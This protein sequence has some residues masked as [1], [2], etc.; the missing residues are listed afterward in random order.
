MDKEALQQVLAQREAELDEV[1]KR[2]EAV[3]V[4]MQ[5]QRLLKEEI[6]LLRGALNGGAQLALS[7][8]P[9]ETSPDKE[10]LIDALRRV[11]K[12]SPTRMSA[13]EITA[14]LRKEGRRFNKKDKNGTNTVRGLLLGYGENAPERRRYFRRIQ[15][16][17]GTFYESIEKD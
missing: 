11:L 17:E 6:K 2:L 4:D 12:A 13:P 16:E 10:L 3:R 7:I 15:L 1:E 5:K 9:I 14:R 8:E